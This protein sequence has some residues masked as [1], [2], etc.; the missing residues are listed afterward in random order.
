MVTNTKTQVST[1]SGHSILHRLAYGDNPP[2]LITT[3]H[4]TLYPHDKA[5]TDAPVTFKQG[6]GMVVHGIGCVLD[7]KTNTV[8]IQSQTDALIIPDKPKPKNQQE[9]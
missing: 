8:K 6:D 9:Q 7:L 5:V 3:D 4:L 1:L 2:L